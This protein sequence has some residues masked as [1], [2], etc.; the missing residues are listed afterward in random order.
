MATAPQIN[1][2]TYSSREYTVTLTLPSINQ[3][4]LFTSND[5]GATASAG[6]VHSIQY[7]GTSTQVNTALTNTYYEPPVDFVTT[8]FN[9][10]YLQTDD[11]D[12]GTPGS[13]T[14][15]G[16]MEITLRDAHDEFNITATQTY[17]ED[18]IT[19]WNV[20]SITDKRPDVIA[21]STVYT[22]TITLD[23]WTVGTIAGW[24]TTY[25][26]GVWTLTGTKTVCN[27]ALAALAFTPKVDF[28][29]SFAF[30]YSQHQDTDNLDHGTSSVVTVTNNVSHDEF[31]VTDLQTY[32][33]DTTATWN[34]GSVT[35]LRADVIDPSL[36]YT[37]ILTANQ[38]GVASITNWIKDITQEKLIGA[39]ETGDKLGYAVAVEGNTAVCGAYNESE[40]GIRPGA[41]YIY[42]RTGN[43]WTEQQRLLPSDEEHE[44]E[45]GFSVAISGET[46]VVGAW[47]EDLGLVNAGAAYV[48]T[49]SG[50]TWTEEQKMVLT[51][52][53]TADFFGYTVDI[54]NETI[55][56]GAAREDTGAT[57]AGSIY[58]YTRSG[59]TWSLEQQINSTDIT[60]GDEF[61]ESVA[62]YEDS[63][64]AGAPRATTG[65]ALAGAAYVFTRSGTTWTQEQKIVALDSAASDYF[66]KSVDIQNDRIVV[67]VPDDG[68]DVGA[69]Y[70][71]S[72]SG[73]TWTEE[74]KITSASP[75]AGEQFGY[76]ISLDGS[77]ILVGAVD[78]VFLFTKLD[79]LWVQQQM[80]VATDVNAVG[81][82]SGVSLSGS[83]SLIGSPGDTGD[84]YVVELGRY[85]FTGTKTEVNAELASVEVVPASGYDL[86][87]G[88]EYSQTQDTDNRDHG[89]QIINIAIFTNATYTRQGANHGAAAGAYGG[90]A[91]GTISDIDDAVGDTKEYTVRL[92]HTGTPHVTGY[93]GTTYATW[94]DPSQTLTLVGTINQI[95]SDLNSFSIYIDTA[96]TVTV[97]VELD[98]DTLGRVN[99][100]TG[101][102][103]ISA[104]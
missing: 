55:V 87:Y 9:L 70:I 4:K 77:D 50:T 22:L 34:M 82:G 5:G 6:G 76:S 18:T 59:T 51:S 39:N 11:D 46:I 13:N 23:D 30:T 85:S 38:S 57:D 98:D 62:I 45:F 81:F 103:N 104:S 58:V 7:V 69:A 42:T 3:G 2:E 16:V 68:T 101:T 72:R 60:A 88:I 93:N 14:V 25:Q 43:V 67:G 97:S 1:L 8:P 71:Y 75:F 54:Y 21:P 37:A 64:V 79:T 36:Q 63:I 27:A 102:Y 89:S 56:V 73:T 29:G 49:R 52:P 32:T 19:S 66:G 94:D 99:A 33:V 10:T 83:A 65:G 47:S 96:G 35:D 41:V 17:D 90:Y 61:G 78:T 44:M 28:T 86:A 74:Q 91:G 12:N 40:N 48:F 80:I 53:T 15:N 95:N 100:D 20:G 26:S 92:I 84:V 24:N 31:S